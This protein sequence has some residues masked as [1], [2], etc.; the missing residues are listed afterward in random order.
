MAVNLNIKIKKKDLWL[1]SAI[2]IFLI[3]VGY[4]VAYDYLG[5][6]PN[7]GHGGD[8]VFIHINGASKDLQQAITNG[9]FNDCSLIG[10][11]FSGNIV[12]GHS[13]ED[14][15]INV[16]G[17]IKSLQESI[18]DNSLSSVDSGTSPSNFGDLSHENT[19]DEIL[20]D[21]GGSEKTL[22]QAIN[23][24][25]FTQKAVYLNIGMSINDPVGLSRLVVATV[26]VKSCNSGGPLVQGA[27]VDGH[28]TT[29]SVFD[30]S[31]GTTN[32]AGQVSFDFETYSLL[33]MDV[34][35]TVDSVTIDGQSYELAGETI[36]TI[37][38]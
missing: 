14:I 17:N 23:D 22:Q 34:S 5:S 30:E 31:P 24:G 12:Q 38:T 9:N 3:G 32:S 4:V 16:G 20:I 2:M 33:G 15:I 29:A 11:S 1:L 6:I 36:D 25:D 8:N 26:T 13:G 19:G 27:V 18:N 7:P 37:I 35:F 10:G 28:W 21:M